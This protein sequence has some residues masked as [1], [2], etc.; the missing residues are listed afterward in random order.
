MATQ[1]VQRGVKRK[2]TEPED[3]VKEDMRDRISRKLY[4]SLKEVRKAAKKA[5][6]FETQK[7]VK[8]LKVLRADADSHIQEIQE[9][10]SQLKVLKNINHE[11]IGNIAIRSKLKKDKLLSQNPS[12]AS[13]IS[14]D[15]PVEPCH[16]SDCLDVKVEARL[17]S[18]K[19]LSTEVNTVVASLK[20]I[21]QPKPA[22]V[23]DG[24][25]SVPMRSSTSGKV[26]TSRNRE[27]SD[28]LDDASDQEGSWPQ[29][30]AKPADDGWES[31]TVDDEPQQDAS[32]SGIGGNC[33][34]GNSGSEG[35]NSDEDDP[36][37]RPPQH[38][39]DG[40][41]A[42]SKP[43]STES[44]FLPSLS[45]GFTRGDSDSEWSD[46]EADQV[47]TTRKNRRGQRARRAIWEK[48]Y[49]KNA[50]HLKKRAEA[51]SRSNQLRGMSRDSKMN[52]RN[53][54]APR[55]M[56]GPRAVPRPALNNPSASA[57]WGWSGTPA[58]VPFDRQNSKSRQIV[59]DERP[60]HPSWEA[61]R[62]MKEKDVGSI[63][64]S[65]GTRIK[66][67]D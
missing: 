6:T 53:T 62:K 17:L 7:L 65:Q 43:R 54:S 26:D 8:K 31:G 18:S 23:S 52:L 13:A 56:G 1:N 39:S 9:L 58:K 55:H 64:P 63:V 48:K 2:R 42:K 10:E 25:L 16:A 49:G 34:K 21:I 30:A 11:R 22:H 14:T 4:H 37:N 3:D 28:E 61:K 45:V 27:V 60:L 24:D 5:K 47:D 41:K 40:S 50:V 33:A 67:N 20:S 32:G 12:V 57:Q 59:E 19:A 51:S 29:D 66:F 35:S 36:S 15:I 46:G 44:R 38:A